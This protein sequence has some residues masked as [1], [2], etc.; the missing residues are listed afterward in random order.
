M[1]SFV[2]F[3]LMIRRPPRSTRTDTLFPYTTLFRS[4]REQHRL[5]LFLRPHQRQPEAQPCLLAPRSFFRPTSTGVIIHDHDNVCTATE[6]SEPGQPPQGTNPRGAGEFQPLN[7]VGS[8]LGRTTGGERV[9]QN[10]WIPVV[11]G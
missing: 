5:A 11:A 8:S 1:F 6:R 10:V 2:F 7:H 3:F 4:H 9:L